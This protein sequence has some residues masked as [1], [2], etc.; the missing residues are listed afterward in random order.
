M[1]STL[2]EVGRA[3]G[4]QDENYI[5]QGVHHQAPQMPLH[6]ETA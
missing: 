6:S 3:G 5:A 1:F 2:L 4:L